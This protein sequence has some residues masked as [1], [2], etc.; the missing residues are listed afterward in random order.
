M[1]P[2]SNSPKRIKLSADAAMNKDLSKIGIKSGRT[3]IKVDKV[4][5]EQTLGDANRFLE[6]YSNWEYENC[7][8]RL[9]NAAIYKCDNDI[10]NNEVAFD[11][12]CKIVDF[13][14][15]KKNMRHGTSS[16]KKLVQEGVEKMARTLDWRDTK[17]PLTPHCIRY[18]LHSDQKS[19]LGMPWH[20][21]ECT[22]TMTTII[23]NAQQGEVSYKGGELGFARL[24]SQ[25]SP[26]LEGLSV[27][28]FHGCLF[29]PSTE[30]WFSYPHNG[31][32]IFDSLNSA[33]KV[34]DIHLS[35][36]PSASNPKIE[37]RLFSI[38]ASPDESYVEDL[39]RKR[40]DNLV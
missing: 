10:E 21:D 27:E 31:G 24:A 5:S 28:D 34:N 14:D 1:H 32:F 16:L 3:I 38:F 4:F 9:L 17:I 18:P 23:S 19:I 2:V 8:N 20:T 11:S 26:Y 37:R 33:H 29:Y 39:S 40:E 22:L 13:K 35:Y 15:I 12:E 6:N 30:S 25:D 36:S 7:G